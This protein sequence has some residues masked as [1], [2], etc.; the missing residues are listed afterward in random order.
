MVK[1]MNLLA[2]ATRTIKMHTLSMR[3]SDNSPQITTITLHNVLYIP[4]LL[5]K[6]EHVTRLMSQR[7]AHKTHIKHRQ[8]FIDAANFSIIEVGDSYIPMDQHTH[9][10]LLTIHTRIHPADIPTELAFTTISRQPEPYGTDA[11]VISPPRD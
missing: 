4:D 7:V 3:K 10:N 8:I 2:V 11:L 9:H 6:G 5:K 1:G